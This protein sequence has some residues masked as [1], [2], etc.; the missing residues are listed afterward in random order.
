[1]QALP[2]LSIGAAV[3]GSAVSAY[4]SVMA[5]RETARAAAFEQDQL[6]VQ[7]E[8]QKIA[9]DQAEARRREELTSSLETIQAIRSGRG[10]GAYSPTGEAILTSAIEDQEHNIAIER[11]NALSSADLSRRAAEM[12]GRKARTS[13]LAG[14][15]TAASTLLTGA[16]KAAS[17]YSYPTARAG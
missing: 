2:I 13:L 9:A 15:L 5:G 10:V 7:G 1:M 6:R 3:A 8:M 14:N 17:I 12:A 16:G 11:L 4:G